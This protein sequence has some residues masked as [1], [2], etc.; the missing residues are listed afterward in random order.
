MQPDFVL[1][2]GLQK[3]EGADQVGVQERLGMIQRVVVVGLGGVVHHRV[4]A[5]HQCVDEVGVGDI[6]VHEVHPGLG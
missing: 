2:H 3:D 1:A 6:S 5:G 4:G